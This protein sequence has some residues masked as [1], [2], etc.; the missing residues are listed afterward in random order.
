MVTV[1]DKIV[2]KKLNGVDILN[3]GITGSIAC[4]KSTVSN[5]LKDK[6]YTIIDADKL[7]H[8]ALTSDEVREKLEKSFGLRII[9]NNEISREKLG[10]LVFGNEENLKILNSIVHPYI[11][12]QILQ[13]QEKH[14]DERLVFLDIALLFE[15][16]FED[17]VEK[18]IVVHINEKEQLTR[19]MNRNSLSSEAAMNRIKSQMSSEDKSKLGD[20]VINN[21]NT[22]EETYRQIDLILDE[23]ERGVIKNDECIRN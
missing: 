16:G 10:K 4:G 15:A 5:Y 18:I 8:I 13:L 3:I 22:K 7:G 20:Y 17:L 11:R 14:S 23:L 2:H 21:S 6:G 9:E 19:L 1:Y 12:R